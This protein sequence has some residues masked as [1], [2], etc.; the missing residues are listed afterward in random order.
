MTNKFTPGPWLIFPAPCNP[1]D[2]TIAHVGEDQVM[3]VVASHTNGAANTR[4]IA[5][6][7]E[8]YALLL[9][10]ELFDHYDS[11]LQV[12]DDWCARVSALLRA[13]E[14]EP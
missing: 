7:P 13:I 6:A 1:I 14:G 4:L 5:K 9:E 12:T 10:S 2:S 3:H 8:M 11:G